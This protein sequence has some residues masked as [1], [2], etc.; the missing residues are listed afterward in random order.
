MR[1]AGVKYG[2][3][4]VYGG[5]RCGGSYGGMHFVVRGMMMWVVLVCGMVNCGMVVCYCGVGYW[6]W[7][8]AV[9]SC[10]VVCGMVVW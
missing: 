5:V 8:C 9:C 6:A 1:Y 10:E 3:V 7:W 2:W 4:V